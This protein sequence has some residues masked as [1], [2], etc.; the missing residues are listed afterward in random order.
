MIHILLTDC[1]CMGWGFDLNCV[2]MFGPVSDLLCSSELLRSNETTWRT[3]LISSCSTNP[4]VGLSANMSIL[5]VDISR[6]T[7]YLCALLMRSENWMNDTYP[8]DGLHKIGR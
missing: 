3:L 4:P 1:I 6:L 2:P 8:I 5:R 7:L